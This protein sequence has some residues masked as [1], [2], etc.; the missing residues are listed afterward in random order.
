MRRIFYLLAIFVL[1]SF[2]VRGQG[3]LSRS[4]MGFSIG[5]MNYLGDLNDQSMFGTVSLAGGLMARCNLDSRWAI[6]IGGN[7][8]HVSGGN[9]DVDALRNLSFRSYIAEGFIRAEFN[10]LP[11]GLGSGTLKRST[12]YLFCGIGFFKFNPQA[13]YINASDGTSEWY[14]LQPLGTEGQGSSAYPDRAKYQLIDVCMPF[15]LGYRWRISPGLHLTAEYGWRKTWTDYLDDVSTTYVGSSVLLGPGGGG[16]I[17]AQLADRSG[18]VIHGYVNSPGIKRGDD[19]LT[20]WYSY[21]SVTLSFSAE[22]LF[23]WMRGKRCEL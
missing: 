22:L 20:D 2:T 19:S 6:S 18:E 16:S 17:A 4:E 13:Q 5:G 23:G 12:P 21:F 15:G 7:Y 3:F 1:L 9:P 11:Y 8:G 10:F 14:D